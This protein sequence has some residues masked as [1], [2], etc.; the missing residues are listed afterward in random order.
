LPVSS[1]D[2]EIVEHGGAA[3]ACAMAE[4]SMQISEIRSEVL[5]AQGLLSEAVDHLS[6]SF[7]DVSAHAQ[8]QRQLAMSVMTA[9]EEPDFS[10]CRNHLGPQIRAT[11][12]GAAVAVKAA[13]PGMTMVPAIK[14]DGEQMLPWTWL[15]NGRAG[16]AA[17]GEF[18]KIAV[19]LEAAVNKAVLSLQFQD[20]IS[21][22]LGHVGRRLDVLD[23]VLG[24][25]RRLAEVFRDSGDPEAKLR[26]LDALREHVGQLP[27]KLLILKNGVDNN[28]VSQTGYVS[29]GVELF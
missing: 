12:E 7:R 11:Q 20:V 17:V 4:F 25:E 3:I 6:D 27:Q 10:G 16:D 28:P 2:Q 8:H 22:L 24:D 15:R 23:E 9:D 5:R 19:A 13:V 29:G 14:T 26:A 18:N 21:Q 1:H